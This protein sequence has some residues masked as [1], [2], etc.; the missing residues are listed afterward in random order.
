MKGIVASILMIFSMSAVAADGTTFCPLPKSF[1]YNASSGRLEAPGGW[2]VHG[3]KKTKVVKFKY[4]EA[5]PYDGQISF[6]YYDVNYSGMPMEMYSHANYYYVADNIDGVNWRKGA[7]S[8]VCESAN[9]A[10]C[11]FHVV[12]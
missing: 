1:K 8:K 4:V 10:D 2:S 5:S 3:D 12:M 9:P 6:C 7:S 11:T